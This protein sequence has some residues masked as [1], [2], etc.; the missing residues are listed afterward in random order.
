[1]QSVQKIDINDCETPQA[2]PRLLVVDDVADNRAIL[3]RRLVRRGF[4]V[5]EAIGG[6]DALDKIA[7]ESFDLVLLDIM[8]PDINGNEVLRRIR[9][10]FSEI[11]LPVIMVTAKGLSDDVVES[12]TLGANDYVTKPV[13]FA[14]ALAR[15]QSNLQRKL[16]ADR[17]NQEKKSAESQAAELKVTVLKNETQ[18]LDESNRRQQSEE[19]L[20]F[21]AFHDSLTGLLN[22][23][24]FNNAL[25][26]T[27][28]VTK[29]GEAETALL[30]IDLNLFKQ[31]NDAYGHEVGDQLLAAVGARLSETIGEGMSVA[32]LGGDEFAVITTAAHQPQM[33]MAMSDKVIEA[34]GRP[35]EIAGHQ[36]QIGASCGIACASDCA[37]QAESLVK[38][39]DLAMYQAKGASQQTAVLFTPDMLTAQNQRRQMEQDLRH[40]VANGDLQLFYQPL[41]DMK[42]RKIVAFEALVRWLHPTFGMLPPDVFIPLAE[43]IN[44]IDQ[45]GNWVI[46]TACAQAAQWPCGIAVAVNVSPLQFRET[47]LL[48][49]IIN[50]LSSSGL[51]PRR[52]ELE[53]TES[54]L[55]N[56]SDDLMRTLSSIRDLGVKL[57]MDDFGTGYSS[58]SYLERFRFDKIKIDKKFIQSMSAS[59]ETSAIVSAIINLS[60]TIGARTTAEGIETEEQ[61]DQIS[62]RGCNQGQGYLFSRPVA[63]T[64]IGALIDDYGCLQQLPIAGKID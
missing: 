43:E 30:F 10:R 6:Q 23:Q 24:G 5:V 20:R 51:A 38:A 14:V 27:L 60:Q 56:Q 32:R 39:A 15:I 31:V 7:A 45:L 13:D 61:F 37:N 64:E 19:Q 34:L 63:A 17:L 2:Q 49:T 40:A 50:A 62:E 28:E 42:T 36:L 29:R 47:S 46:R 52:L 1:M 18:L 54:T 48:P 41:V 3:M 55:L 53:L 21:L 4:E 9:E 44:V 22:R 12:I 59:V 35:F 8:M 33:T 16:L 25:A 11:E 58:L 57:A 26:E